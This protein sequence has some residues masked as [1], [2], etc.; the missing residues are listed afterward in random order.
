[1]KGNQTMRVGC[2]LAALAVGLASASAAEKL[3][4]DP[5]QQ[6]PKPDTKAPDAKKPV[7]AARAVCAGHHRLWRLEAGWEWPDD[8]QCP[9]RRERGERQVPGVRGQ[10]EGRGS[11]GF[12][13]RRGR[14]PEESRL[15]LQS[16]CGDLQDARGCAR[17]TTA[18]RP[19]SGSPWSPVAEPAP[20]RRRR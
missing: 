7:S 11:P 12:L 10:R 9:T 18:L 4:T 2:L 20:E 14:F 17:A 15:S 1:M 13:E 16:Q 3:N 19:Y 5:K 6:L 8:R